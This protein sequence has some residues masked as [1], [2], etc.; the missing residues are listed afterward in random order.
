MPHQTGMPQFPVLSILDTSAKGSELNL[1]RASLDMEME[2]RLRMHTWTS[3]LHVVQ[4]C[5]ALVSSSLHL[6]LDVLCL[7]RSSR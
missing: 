4:V 3:N 7:Y 1:T 5:A 6:T 2:I